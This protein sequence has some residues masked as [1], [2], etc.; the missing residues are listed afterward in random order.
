MKIVAL[1]PILVLSLLAAPLAAE[2]QQEGRVWRIGIL[3]W[4][5][6]PHGDPLREAFSNGL[7]ELGYVEG[8]NLV[9]ERRDASPDPGRYPALA[10]EL[11]AAGVDVIVV[12]GGNPAILAAKSA[13]TTIPIVMMWV[14]DPVETGIVTS[15]ARPGG[16]VTGLTWEEGSDQ[17][18]K[19]L[20][21]FKEVVPTVSRIALIRN[22]TFPGLARYWAPAQTAAHALRMEVY[23][24]D[25]SSVEELD[26][27]V[28]TVLKDRPSAIW[29]VG[30]G[31]IAN[32]RRQALCDFALKNR[33]P[34]LAPDQPWNEAGC[35]ISYVP[36]A[37]DHLRRT[38]IYVDK[39][40]KGA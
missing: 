35:L 12:T 34:T 40:L 36:D 6:A 20:Q 3:S 23:R 1:V 16:N 4:T 11:V 14:I 30:D 26:R 37:R 38:A 25:Y 13:T 27:A 17:V 31:G 15:L 33:F 22:P 32:L 7:R 8:K 29:F 10:A 9:I 24:V 2:A 19:K 28:A 5:R 18:G 39:I 21:L